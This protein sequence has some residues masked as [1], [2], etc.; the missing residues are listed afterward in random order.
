MPL[1]IHKMNLS[2]CRV[3]MS[4]YA[5]RLLLSGQYDVYD[6][7]IA[8]IDQ[9]PELVYERDEAGR[10]LLMARSWAKK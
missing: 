7:I 4:R 5:E 3:N 1:D 2:N 10:I 8:L 6:E 9:K